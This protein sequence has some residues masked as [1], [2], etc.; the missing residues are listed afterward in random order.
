MICF[1]GIVQA[2]GTDVTRIVSSL[3]DSLVVILLVCDLDQGEMGEGGATNC[4]LNLQVVRP[5]L[6]ESSSD[7]IRRDSRVSLSMGPKTRLIATKTAAFACGTRRM[8]Q[9]IDGFLRMDCTLL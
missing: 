3:R 6:Y 9:T 1:V 8:A 2:L 7:L 5:D 4:E